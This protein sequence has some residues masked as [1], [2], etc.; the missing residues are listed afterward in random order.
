M[1]TSQE[2][3]NQSFSN[4]IETMFDELLEQDSELESFLDIF[5]VHFDE[6]EWPEE[7]LKLEW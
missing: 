2:L 4:E 6:I 1:Q 3:F 7:E 5:E